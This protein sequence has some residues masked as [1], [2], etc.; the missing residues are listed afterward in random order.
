MQTL[1]EYFNEQISNNMEL[2]I[3]YNDKL[4][5]L[6]YPDDDDD[7]YVYDS[8]SGDVYYE[9]SVDKVL[10]DFIIDGKTLRELIITE[11]VEITI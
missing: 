10:D 4:F 9:G 6:D 11:K 2:F 3:T 1:M 8:D 7:C 5:R